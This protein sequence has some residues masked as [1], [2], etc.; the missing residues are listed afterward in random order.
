MAAELVI[1][2]NRAVFQVDYWSVGVLCYEF[3]VGKPPFEAK[4][5]QETYVRI[6]NV[7]YAFPHYLS[8]GARDLIRKVGLGI[9][10]SWYGS[11][12]LSD[13]SCSSV[14]PRRGSTSPA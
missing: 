2:L 10:L 12:E 11:S 3:L 1:V 5:Q 14:T 4:T 7:N 9:A 13:F 8:D 6:T